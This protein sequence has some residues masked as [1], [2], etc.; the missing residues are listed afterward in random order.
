MQTSVRTLRANDTYMRRSG[1]CA[2]THSFLEDHDLPKVD[3]SCEYCGGLSVH[4][5]DVRGSETWLVGCGSARSVGVFWPRARRMFLEILLEIRG[6][7]EKCVSRTF[8]G[9]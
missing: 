8:P 4:S 7:R 2:P 5:H 3:D 9:N 6:W 1:R